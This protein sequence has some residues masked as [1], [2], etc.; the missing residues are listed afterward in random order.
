MW[1]EGADHRK[2]TGI[3]YCQ[4]ACATQRPPTPT[5]RY[6]IWIASVSRGACSWF[7]RGFSIYCMADQPLPLR[8]RQAPFP[9]LPHCD[10]VRLWRALFLIAATALYIIYWCTYKLQSFIQCAVAALDLRA[11]R[12]SPPPDHPLAANAFPILLR[13]TVVLGTR[14]STQLHTSSSSPMPCM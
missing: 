4:S 2:V 12:L 10:K 11:N 1:N 6:S 7:F 9:L 3:F 13:D 14:M 8:V 5:A